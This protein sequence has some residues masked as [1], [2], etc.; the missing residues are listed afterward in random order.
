MACKIVLILVFVLVIHRDVGCCN[1]TPLSINRVA[2]IEPAVISIFDA[3]VSF[4][5]IVKSLI[6]AEGA[7]I[8]SVKVKY[9]AFMWPE[10][11]IVKAL[12][13]F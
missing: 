9:D 5:Y 11:S 7:V 3:N 6:F 2:F 12:H 4:F 13:L 10:E 8:F 1:S